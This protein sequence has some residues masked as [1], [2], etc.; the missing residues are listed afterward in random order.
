MKNV[1]DAGDR[2]RRAALPAL[3]AATAATGAWLIAAD[4][5][6]HPDPVFAPSAA[7][8][9]L[10][11]ARGRRLRQTTELVIGV[12]A[13]VLVAELVVQAL[14]TGAVSL[15]T[16]LLLTI[17]PMLAA[18]AGSTLIVQAAVSA[19]YLVVVAA[20]QGNLIPYR[21]AD[22]LIGG[23]VAI[24]A[25]QLAAARRPLAPL[26]TEA[27]QTYADLADLLD[28]LH[29]A[30]HDCDEDAAHAVLDRAHLLDEQVERLNDAAL[31]A[32]E[33]LQLHVRR[34]R[35][36]KQVRNV[37]ATAHQLD[38]VAGNIEVLAR[39]AATLT[40]LHTC[41][42]DDLGRAVKA[43]A[44]AV[45]SAGDSLATDLT[46]GDDAGRHASQADTDA[47]EA[48][49]IAAKL[50]EDETPPPVT[51]MVGQIRTTA[52]DLLRGVGGDD[53]L[54]RVDEAIGWS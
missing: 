52:V 43:L 19:L 50:L 49:R 7:L 12:A 45:R 54:T 8:I 47:L 48:V 35:R 41:T 16:V 29:G 46:G 39:Y 20:P 34:R 25:S 4:L 9:V 53:P 2:L 13:G 31:A 1:R 6:G 33:T 27:R 38:H 42:P 11:E 40:R 24:V 51:M 28:D 36:L 10:G 22:A 21:F 3:G 23:A 30:L 26:V 32:G 5:I 37:E 18:G 14:G 15:F 44:G 17:A